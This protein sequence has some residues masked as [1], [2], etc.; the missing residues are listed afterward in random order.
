MALCFYEYGKGVG[1]ALDRGNFLQSRE[2]FWEHVPCL[3]HLFQVRAKERRGNATEGDS[4]PWWKEQRPPAR[5]PSSKIYCLSSLAWQL[6]LLSELNSPFWIS[7]FFIGKMK[8]IIS[9]LNVIALMVIEDQKQYMQNANTHNILNEFWWCE[10]R[11]KLT[12][13]QDRS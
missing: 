12:L 5:T 4:T 6:V 2:Y 3:N 7:I 1:V 11:N 9:T 8:I 10:W 13:A